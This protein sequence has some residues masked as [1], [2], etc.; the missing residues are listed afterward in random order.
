MM[1]A[2]VAVLA[3]S[4]LEFG[5]GALAGIPGSVMEDESGDAGLPGTAA[6]SVSSSSN[7]QIWCAVTVAGDVECWGDNYLGMLGNGG[8]DA[9]RTEMPG[10]VVGLPGP[11][12]QVTVGY[13]HVCALMKAGSVWCWG[14]GA[15]GELGNGDTTLVASSTPVEVAG[16]EG[17]IS[18]SAGGQYYPP[19]GAYGDTCAVKGEDGSVWCWGGGWLLGN[20]EPGGGQVPNSPFPT[21]VKAL[22]GDRVT[23]VS[24][25][26]DSA[27]VV[28]QEGS[29]KCWGG[30]FGYGDLGDRTTISSPTPVRVI[31]L[32]G[33]TAVSVGGAY[34][35]NG[36]FACALTKGGDVSCW[37]AGGSYNEIVNLTSPV[38]VKGLPKIAAIS[39]GASDACALARDGA[40]F[41]WG[42]GQDGQLGTT[43]NLHE[44]LGEY[45]GVLAQGDFTNTPVQV[46]QLSKATAIST[47]NAPCAVT[48]GGSVECWGTTCEI[49]LTPVKVDLPV[50]FG[51]AASVSVGGYDDSSAFACAASAP[52]ATN[53]FVPQIECWGANG[54]G[55]LGAGASSTSGALTQ[56]HATPVQFG[57]EPGSEVSAGK[58]GAFACSVSNGT[59]FCSGENDRGQLGNGTNDSQPS[60][61]KVTG[62]P[63]GQ[64]ALHVSA[65]TDSACAVLM[66]GSVW[67]WGSNDNGQLGNPASGDI[68][69]SPV[70][71]ESLAPATMVSVGYK[72]A[73]ALL[74]DTT[75]ECWGRNNHGQLGRGLPLLNSSVPARVVSPDGSGDALSGTSDIAVGNVTTCAVMSESAVSP[76]PGA[77]VCWGLDSTGQLGDGESTAYAFSPIPVLSFVGAGATKVAVGVSDACAV[78]LGGAWCWGSLVTGNGAWVGGVLRLSTNTVAIQVTG[79]EHGVTDIAV[80]S[81]SACAVQN[82]NV[83]CWGYN[84]VGQ[85]GNNGSVDAFLPTKIAGF[86]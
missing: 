26:D 84:S 79:L 41:C 81:D 3:L 78:V 21:R 34:L 9:G 20:A 39:V 2:A 70:R 13:E 63:G 27:C 7:Y 57:D 44:G 46:Q 29:V 35:S 37:G 24:V 22:D 64:D 38:P 76:P 68:S 73:C 69:M 50:E 53:D 49:A 65:G 18:V 6:V 48:A 80:Y 47:G 86:P 8:S 52:G 66:D 36:C 83:Y 10:K 67:C 42:D 12:S 19:W 75:I 51:S 31:G 59:V 45:E 11:A 4:L 28:L 30:Y 62:L 58:W 33:V 15:D 55:Q 56:I 54:Y 14:Y 77:I 23:S 25:G 5:C 71:V 16:L 72:D 61:M 82:G 32:E 85:L 43:S 40:V 60:P 17:V 1:R 74:N